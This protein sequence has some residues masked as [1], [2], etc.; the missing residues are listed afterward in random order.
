MPL[1]WCSL[2]ILSLQL[3]Q[4]LK[5]HFKG[6]EAITVIEPKEVPQPFKKIKSKGSSCGDLA[7]QLP[8]LQTALVVKSFDDELDVSKDIRIPHQLN[9]FEVLIQNKYV[10]LNHVDWKSK[11]YRFNI[12]SFPWINGRESS[13]LV[14][15][16]GKKVDG[17]RFPIGTEVFIAST[18]YRN[19]ES[20]TFQEYTVFDSRLVWRIP[21]ERV[22]GGTFRKKFGLDF[23]GGIGVGLVTAGSALSP[24]IKYER[25]TSEPIEKKNIVIWGGSSS[26]GIYAIQLAR[27]SGSFDK[28]IAVSSAKYTS[29]LE[30]LGAT[31]VIDRMKGESIISKEVGD[32]CAEGVHYGLDTISKS[33]ATSLFRILQNGPNYEK[34]L[35]C[36]VDGP[37]SALASEQTNIAV[38][39][40]N[41]KRFHED[42]S[43][44][45]SFV[46]Y[47][48]Q[49]LESDA[50]KPIRGLR[51]FKGLDNFGHSI[52][53]GLRELKEHGA[54]AEK[55]VVGI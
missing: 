22:A 31:H 5:R 29:Y 46:R 43:Y 40:V 15:K 8:L 13:G 24:F 42:I 17:V 1:S 38:E 28:I 7:G 50:L 21:E 10:G 36:L 30:E 34:T 23:A 52:A 18:S 32:L 39:K 6:L 25:T 47:T 33:T 3:L 53:I 11:T 51:I 9:D 44:G 37:D 19:L 48:S 4:M 2:V 26:V 12:Y 49:L 16:R 41:V 27:S 54:G 20:S 14:V 35:V 45:E 55:F